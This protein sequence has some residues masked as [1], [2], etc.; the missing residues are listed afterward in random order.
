MAVATC[1]DCGN[2]YVAIG[3]HWAA[4]DC[5]Y[6]KPTEKQLDILTGSVMGDGT[7]CREYNSSVQIIMKSPNYL[8]YLDNQFPVL[9]TGVRLYMTASELAEDV[10]ERNFADVVNDENY[11]DQYIWKTRNNP[12]LNPLAEWYSSGEK[13]FPDDIELTPTVLKHW[14]CGDG[15]YKDESYIRLAMANE[16]HNKGKI[17][18]MFERV[19]LPRPNSWDEHRAVWNVNETDEL[20]DYMGESLPD[21]EYKWR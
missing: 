8:E 5:D 13:V 1:H 14:Y 17:E 2:E 3:R 6:Q 12:Y 18:R 4:S 20:F 10:R 19:G 7:V 21:F 11:S 9:G 16:M 15:M